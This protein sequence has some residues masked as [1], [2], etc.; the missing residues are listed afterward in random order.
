MYMDINQNTIQSIRNWVKLD[1]EMRS[2]RNEMNLRKKQ[3]ESI[4]KD[5]VNFMKH[6]DIDS[7]DINNGKI[8]HVT[9]RTNSP[10]FT[11]FPNLRVLPFV[12]QMIVSK[13]CGFVRN[14]SI[15][16]GKLSNSFIIATAVFELMP[17]I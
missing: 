9:R 8:E 14:S 16:V 4:S 7:F 2:L 5:L 10:S 15:N 11:F 17:G 1:N 12:S 6:Q 13:H 3:K